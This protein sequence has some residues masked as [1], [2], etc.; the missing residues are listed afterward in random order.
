MIDETD[1][2]LRQAYHDWLPHVVQATSQTGPGRARVV[3][4]VVSATLTRDPSKIE[5]LQ[6]HNPRYI[7]MSAADYRQVVSLSA[8]Q[9]CC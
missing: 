2:L 3:K 1:R 8:M 6:L 7:A 4:V 9:S 5:R